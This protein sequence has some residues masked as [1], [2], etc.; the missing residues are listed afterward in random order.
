[1]MRLL[2]SPHVRQGASLLQG[3]QHLQSYSIRISKLREV[4]RVSH[5]S[6]TLLLLCLLQQIWVLGKGQVPG[7]VP[8][9]LHAASQRQIRAR[10]QGAHA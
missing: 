2:L 3:M 6:R 5:N 8:W 4:C 10:L 9:P 1:M 7:L